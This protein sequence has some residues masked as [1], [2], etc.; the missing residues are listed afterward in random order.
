MSPRIFF[1]NADNYVLSTTYKY[2]EIYVQKCIKSKEGVI[3]GTAT[4]I[5]DSENFGNKVSRQRV[6]CC[7]LN[8]NK[9]LGHHLQRCRY[10]FDIDNRCWCRRNNREEYF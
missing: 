10:F 5:E 6:N 7:I 1:I 2:L 3:S 8:L 4:Q 9:H